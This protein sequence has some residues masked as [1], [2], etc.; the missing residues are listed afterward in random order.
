MYRATSTRYTILSL[1]GQGGQGNV[2][3]AQD[4]HSGKLVAIKQAPNNILNHEHSVLTFIEEHGGAIAGI[5]RLLDTLAF[6][7]TEGLV[8]EYIA[9]RTL[10]QIPVHS[11]TLSVVL[12]W[13]T[14][15]ITILAHLH[16]RGVVHHDLAETNILIDNEGSLHI[17]DFG[18]AAAYVTPQP[19]NVFRSDVADMLCLA[20]DWLQRRVQDPTPGV[21]ALC[22][23][24]DSSI[25]S[26]F[27]DR[28]VGQSETAVTFLPKWQ[29]A[30]TA[31]FRSPAALASSL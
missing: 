1:L 14:E 2:F 15:C 11:I 16:L 26:L 6:Q 9:G 18:I 17:I 12:Q 5:P 7:G 8:L 20:E 13:I 28:G 4:Q 23:W 24:L 29:Q 22:S 25:D 10:D 3:L 30:K 27:A 19:F 31:L 21:H